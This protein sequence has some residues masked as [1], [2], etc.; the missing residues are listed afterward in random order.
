MEIFRIKGFDS[1]GTTKID[2]VNHL[3]LRLGSANM[4]LEML[5]KDHPNSIETVVQALSKSLT[6]RGGE[7][8][9]ELELTEHYS[10]LEKFPNLVLQIKSAVLTLLNFDEYQDKIEENKGEV[11]VSD[12]LRSYLFL[13]YYLATSLKSI[14]DRDDALA[15]YQNF[16]DTRT[17]LT[18]NPESKW[19]DLS[20]SKEEMQQ[21]TETTHGHDLNYYKINDGKVTYRINRCLWHETTKE[22]N[23]KEFAYSVC[24]HYDFEAIKTLNENFI[25]TR[26]RTIIAGNQFCD[27]CIHDTRVVD[28]VE[29]PTNE[30][31]M[32]LA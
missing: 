4:F 27:F 3:N 20:N 7:F 10:E 31:W 28:K 9:P 30:F 12:F 19:P 25:L 6:D 14:L 15:Y 17:K 24:C 2:L 18:A 1:Q 21:F 11:L 26:K 29:H 23:D 8:V 13:E 16:V 22:L 5:G 32:K